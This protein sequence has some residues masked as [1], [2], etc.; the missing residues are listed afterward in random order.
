MCKKLK[1]S[2]RILNFKKQKGMM[3]FIV[4]ILSSL[5][6]LFFL[7]QIRFIDISPG[8]GL[9]VTASDNEELTVWNTSDGTRRVIN[10]TFLHF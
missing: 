5:L 4:P 1:Y 9:C 2:Y 7:S 10:T 3:G 6:I 8:G